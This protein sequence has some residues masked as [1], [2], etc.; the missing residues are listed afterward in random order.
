MGILRVSYVYTLKAVIECQKKKR[1]K[2]RRKNKRGGAGK[3]YSG[4]TSEV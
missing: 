1:K 2:A 3:T 4:E